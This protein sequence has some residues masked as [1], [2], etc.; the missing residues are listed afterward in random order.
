MINRRVFKTLPQ[1]GPVIIEIES[2]IEID[3]WYL[4]DFDHAFDFDTDPERPWS[5]NKSAPCAL[6][7]Q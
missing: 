7:V 3:F 2:V 5:E 1:G 6:G 4:S